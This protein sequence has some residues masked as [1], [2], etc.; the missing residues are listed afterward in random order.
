M[1]VRI[2]KKQRRKYRQSAREDVAEAEKLAW[3]APDRAA[4]LRRLADVWAKMGSPPK[5]KARRRSRVKARQ[6]T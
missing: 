4:V 6:K 1:T 2:N 3:S 5:C